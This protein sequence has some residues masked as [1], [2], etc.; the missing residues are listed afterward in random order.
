MLKV[1][2]FKS[3]KKPAKM[4]EMEL[5]RRMISA[6]AKSE[7]EPGGI[8]KL[9]K[10]CTDADD[11]M[12]PVCQRH[13]DCAMGLACIVTASWVGWW[14]TVTNTR[15]WMGWR[16]GAAQSVWVLNQHY[17]RSTFGSAEASSNLTNTPFSQVQWRLLRNGHHLKCVVMVQFV[18]TYP[19]LFPKIKICFSNQER[20]LLFLLIYHIVIIWNTSFLSL[21]LRTFCSI[22]WAFSGM[23]GSKTYFWFSKP[24]MDALKNKISPDFF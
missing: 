9:D 15:G 13:C 18:T 1:S 22:V 17:L 10:A 8:N 16:A 12:M 5:C 7:C 23:D 3:E 21:N 11:W 14:D 6:V 24:G 4:V 20:K 2:L 19:W